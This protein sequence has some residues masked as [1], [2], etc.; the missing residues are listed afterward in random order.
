MPIT[1][2]VIKQVRAIAHMED[3]PKG[4]KIKDRNNNILFD[5]SLTVGMDYDEA[6]FD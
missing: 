4:I 5:S 6:Q 2:S 1:P 3:M